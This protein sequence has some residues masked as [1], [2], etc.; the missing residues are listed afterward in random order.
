MDTTENGQSFYPEKERDRAARKRVREFS[1]KLQRLRE[2]GRI[3]ILVLGPAIVD[4][5][6]NSEEG[7]AAGIEF[8]L[9][10]SAFL[11]FDALR[12][13]AG[14]NGP[15]VRLHVAS[16]A[17]QNDSIKKQILQLLLEQAN[18]ASGGAIRLKDV[19]TP[20][21]PHVNVNVMHRES[22]GRVTYRH[23][24]EALPAWDGEM[25]EEAIAAMKADDGGI[26]YLAAS[27]GQRYEETL[28]DTLAELRRQGW[29]VVL[30]PASPLPAGDTTEKVLSQTDLLVAR[31]VV[32]ATVLHKWLRPQVPSSRPDSQSA[33]NQRKS[34]E[35]QRPFRR[36]VWLP[37]EAKSKRLPQQLPPLILA[38]DSAV[39]V[40]LIVGTC[41]CIALDPH[42]DSNTADPSPG[43][44]SEVIARFLVEL[45]EAPSRPFNSNQ[46][47]GSAEP[48]DVEPLRKALENAVK[49]DATAGLQ[50][51]T[52]LGRPIR[53]ED[54]G[55]IGNSQQIRNIET[56]LRKLAYFLDAPFTP[57]IDDICVL[58]Q[59][60]TGTGKDLLAH[61]VHTV[62]ARDPGK[63]IETSCGD[64]GGDLNIART[65]IF[66]A[67]GK[68]ITGVP[69]DVQGAVEKAESGGAVF[70]N[71]ISELPGEAQTLLLRYLQDRKYTSVGEATSKEAQNVLVVAA[72]NSPIRELVRNGNFREDLYYRLRV[73]EFNLPPLRDRREDIELLVRHLSKKIIKGEH[74]PVFSS[75]AIDRLREYQWPGNVRQLESFLINLLASR[76][77]RDLWNGPP[78]TAEEIEMRLNEMF[79]PLEPTSGSTGHEPELSNE[80]AQLLDGAMKAIG[81]KVPESKRDFVE[82]IIAAFL[83]KTEAT[84][85][86]RPKDK[87]RGMQSARSQLT[88]EDFKTALLSNGELQKCLP[89][90]ARGL[91]RRLKSDGILYRFCPDVDGTNKPPS[92]QGCRYCMIRLSDKVIKKITE[93]RHP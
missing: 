15:S 31:S 92:H 37:A 79:G 1:G 77:W 86:A 5:N 81:S 16:C 70:F 42:S 25:L 59:G 68:R 45:L 13:L 53:L 30:H 83:Q 36:L 21:E 72:T 91:I 17:S 56:Q 47:L 39:D 7:G 18:I 75:G 22:A 38:A 55:I 19:S 50:A 20:T 48:R 9:G 40:E 66:G 24:P 32:L 28:P 52:L 51:V 2:S 80:V 65:E 90:D 10:G 57:R 71:E 63:V 84:K 93:Q 49:Q 54:F 6:V 8:E 69:F 29:L 43:K 88:A 34:T 11:V 33:H 44:R 58:I 87:A 61:A 78:V 76:E 64:Y 14:D 27:H 89:G 73:I 82:A 41:W 35:A 3:P 62:L 60:E 67:K 74:V 4:C 23:S 85:N 26:L 46:E 12:K